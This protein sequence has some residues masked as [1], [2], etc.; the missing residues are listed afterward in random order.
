MTK[1]PNHSWWQS[2]ASVGCAAIVLF[3]LYGLT[4]HT[5]Q[6]ANSFAAITATPSAVKATSQPAK[7]CAD[8]A[9]VAASNV[10]QTLCATGTVRSVGA[11]QTA[12]YIR[13]KDTQFQIISYDLKRDYIGGLRSGQ[14]VRVTGKVS[15]LGS[16]IVITINNVSALTDCNG[17]A[18]VI[19]TRAASNS[20][21]PTRT[22]R[23]AGQATPT[24]SSGNTQP[25]Q[26][27]AASGVGRLTVIN[28]SSYGAQ[29]TIWGPADKTIDAPPG[30]NV[31]VEIPTGDYGWTSFANG[32]QLRPVNNLPVR[33][34]H[35]VVISVLPDNGPCGLTLRLGTS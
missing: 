13:F 5:T 27:P 4:A 24:T 6:A 22:P 15:K 26:A 29:F 34:T 17:K 8:V 12:S 14:C 11:D 33:T 2:L 21:A 35:T 23:P 20:N 32:C 19:P 18:L 3:L 7:N 31:T 16:R 30:Q 25:T 1:Q 9:K 28:Q 10:G